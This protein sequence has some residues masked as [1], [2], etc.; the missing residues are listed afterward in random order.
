MVSALQA[1]A[2]TGQHSSNIAAQA[3]YLALA[4]DETQDAGCEKSAPSDSD[5]HDR[6][7][8]D[9][10]WRVAAASV[11][12]LATACDADSRLRSVRV[13]NRP[14]TMAD[15]LRAQPLLLR[16]RLANW[17]ATQRWGRTELLAR[18]GSSNVSAAPV[19]YPIRFGATATP[20]VLADFV[21]TNMAR[22][23]GDD[24]TEVD[25][26]VTT[27]VFDKLDASS[28]LRAL[29][30]DFDFAKGVVA[31]GDSVI[32]MLPAENSTEA[33]EFFVG[34]AQSGSPVHRHNAALNALVFGV[35]RWFMWP[36]ICQSERRGH[37]I[38]LHAHVGGA[39][40]PSMQ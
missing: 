19:P 22:E 11:A 15:V 13:L 8:A 23:S 25:R 12:S 1:M 32:E 24:G 5:G 34:G 40:Q 38:P 9:S 29:R 14:L 4:T 16:G 7:A 33:A 20:V 31:R 3:A 37:H 28:G 30:T 17:S 39:S 27:Y 2:R 36:A 26:L 35:K 21:R 10:G 6:A 18:Y